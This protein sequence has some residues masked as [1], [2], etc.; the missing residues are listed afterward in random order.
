ML[1]GAVTGA[2]ALT[3][4]VDVESMPLAGLPARA[5]FP[6]AQRF[7]G[8]LKMHGRFDYTYGNRTKH[9]TVVGW[10]DDAPPPWHLDKE[11]KYPIYTE[12]ADFC[13][14]LF[15]SGRS[16]SGSGSLVMELGTLAGASSRCLA[17]GLAVGAQERGS[18]PSTNA[19]LPPVYA[20]FDDF[21]L[22]PMTAMK[23][24]GFT[25]HHPE[26]IAHQLAKQQGARYD[27]SIW[28]T[29]MVRPVYPAKLG[30]VITFPGDIR[31]KV[32]QFLEAVPPDVPIEL[33]S[34]DSAKSHEHFLQQAKS[35]WPR[36]R[37]GSVMH[38][39]DYLKGQFFFFFLSYVQTGDVEIMYI[40]PTSASWVFRVR[41][42]PLDW[43]RVVNFYQKH[44]T[45]L[46]TSAGK[47]KACAQMAK[48]IRPIMDR[49]A[50][51]QSQRKIYAK[52][53]DRQ[54]GITNAT[55][56]LKSFRKLLHLDAV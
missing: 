22:N 56:S 39:M 30:P 47:R 26:R 29:L 25:K 38:L 31:A 50:W 55:V 45:S 44:G 36:L 52:W 24:L 53:L 20:A 46:D 33:F 2:A 54:A 10:P 21:N 15:L 9:N 14:I 41:R 37:V 19:R 48:S 28:K 17:A 13:P 6:T 5:E 3:T 11:L 40:S 42:A 32:P 49:Y 51:P 7:D 27:V 35:I 1:V 16:V 8:L 18:L 12:T 23:R 4:H 43:S 34:I